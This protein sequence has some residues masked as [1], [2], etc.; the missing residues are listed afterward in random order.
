[1]YTSILCAPI[2]QMCSNCGYC[3]IA[4]TK[5]SK[6]KHL[7]STGAVGLPDLGSQVVGR[8]RLIGLLNAHASLLFSKTWWYLG[9][10]SPVLHWNLTEAKHTQHI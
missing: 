10:N 2:K 9:Y 3:L 6:A 8:Q 1:M 4:L 5:A 7:S